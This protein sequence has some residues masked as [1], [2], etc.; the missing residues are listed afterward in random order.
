MLAPVAFR[1]EWRGRRDTKLR[2][3]LGALA[4]S[5][6][7]HVPLT[8]LIAP[9]GLLS[10]VKL[11][12]DSEPEQLDEWVG[13][14]VTLLDESELNPEPSQGEAPAA[15]DEAEDEDLELDEAEDDDTDDQERWVVRKP[16]GT[17]RPDAGQASKPTLDAADAGADAQLAGDAG[18]DAGGGPALDAAPPQPEPPQPE[19]PQ[20]EPPQRNEAP[21]AERSKTIRD[22]M[23]LAGSAGQ[24]SDANANVRLIVF[25]DRIRR[26]RV[27]AL[28]GDLLGAVDQWRAFFKTAGLDPIKDIDRML[29]SGPQ[30]RES[31][32]A[33][34][35]L[36]HRATE[37]RIH[38]AIDSLVKA[39]KQGG[40]WLEPGIAKAK[41]DRADRVFAQT[42]PGV[43]LVGPVGMEV[44][45]KQLFG[46]LRFP[47]P[48]GNEVLSVFLRT[49]YRA[50]KGIPFD[51]PES[52][53]WVRMKLSPGPRDGVVAELEAQDESAA[54]A[55]SHA[56]QFEG[57]LD[58]VTRIKLPGPLARLLGKSEKRLIESI[59]FTARGDRIIGRVVAT[60]SQLAPLLES[61]AEYSKQL[62]EEA[63]QKAKER[64]AA[65]AAAASASAAPSAPVAPSAPAAPSAETPVKKPPPSGAPPSSAPTAAPS[66]SAAPATA[67]SAEPSA[68]G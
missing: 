60:G 27:G 23:A 17:D 19:P 66:S 64:K 58:A 62:N 41:V 44:Q 14:P 21:V 55:L 10:L 33:V 49:P 8:P 4:V 36:R 40:Q 35:V 20:P 31:S 46:K 12:D 2:L 29:I 30:L 48:E 18:L 56:R 28:I 22:P 59:S 63:K 9:L 54:S 42:G 52:I 5:L 39:D 51:M 37:T 65:E 15:A 3:V 47:N 6:L 38:Q 11:R 32:K 7:L 25:G 68:G 16:T 45:A 50:F 26:H 57:A 24:V 13:I 61:I 1:A 43:V 53:T 67:P 34:I